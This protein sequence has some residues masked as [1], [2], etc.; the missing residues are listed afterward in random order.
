M[1]QAHASNQHDSIR[2]MQLPWPNRI[3]SIETMWS[4]WF[5]PIQ[6]WNVPHQSV[7]RTSHASPVCT[8]Y[9]RAVQ[10][11]HAN[12]VYGDCMWSPIHSGYAEIVCESIMQGLD[13]SRVHGDC[14]RVQHTVI[15]RESN[16]RWLYASPTYG[17]CRW[18]KH[19]VIVQVQYAGVVCGTSVRWLRVQ[20]T[21]IVCDSNIRWLHE[22]LIFG[23]W[24]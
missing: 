10:G 12:R 20:R 23:D 21:V 14:T 19:T 9:L 18:V 7:Y 24:M 3:D 2:R 5:N 4:K 15:V 6:S 16:I 13:A 17:D 8:D 11:L 22:S 1:S